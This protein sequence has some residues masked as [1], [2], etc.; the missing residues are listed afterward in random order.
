MAMNN[1]GAGGV[2]GLRLISMT[3]QRSVRRP[4]E[5]DHAVVNLGAVAPFP[6]DGDSL[7][8]TVGDSNPGKMKNLP[9]SS[10][11][12]HEIGQDPWWVVGFNLV[13]ASS[14]SYI[15][16][17]PQLIM[18]H[19]GW[20]AGPIIMVLLNAVFFY[21]NC[22]LGSLHET[23]GSAKFELV[24]LSATS[25]VLQHPLYNQLK[26]RKNSKSEGLVRRRMFTAVWILQFTVL[27]VFCIGTFI[28]AGT[29][30]EAI[31]ASYSSD[32]SKISLSE[33]VAV[34]GAC[35]SVFAFVVP[36]LH[37]LRLYST[38]SLVLTMIITFITIGISIKDG[39]KSGVARDYSIVGTK[40][41]KWFS[42]MGALSVIGFAFNTAILPELQ[43]DVRPPTV[44]NIY[45]ALGLQYTLGAIPIIGL[46]LI[47]Y[48][49]YGNVVS[50][51][52]LESNSGP[53]WLVTVAKVAAFFQILVTLH[54]Y[55][56][57]MF[58]FF[59]SKLLKA[60]RSLKPSGNV[61]N[62]VLQA[63]GHW[64]ARTVL[65][66]FLTRITFI[67]ITTLLGAMFPFFGDIL[68]LS[69]AV[70]VFPIDFGLVHH[71]YLKVKG[72]NF[73][74]YRR[75]W[76]WLMIVTAVLLTIASV[77]G[78]SRNI[79]AVASTYRIFHSNN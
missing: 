65:V 12:P 60:K 71:M 39:V 48:W 40:A 19:L 77:T 13:A 61:E 44:R 8:F 38:I 42:A 16:S 1:N 69:G 15:L 59:D 11:S 4:A 49:A 57:P 33:W 22:L 20:I 35:Y 3:R 46:T 32:P 2:Q 64:S 27:I 18:T 9:P 23:G 67:S 34:A 31:Y 26:F 43:A 24:I 78:A 29:T 36:T 56:L 66:R 14:S 58:E 10:A 74:L 76:H 54:I 17:Y 30:L 28:W 73:S 68:E 53:K 37:S 6:A 79:I 21:N 52:I 72:K 75:T 5:N 25:M 55:A 70:I 63:G 41:D 45:K 47:G 50:G 51:F 7:P 62:D